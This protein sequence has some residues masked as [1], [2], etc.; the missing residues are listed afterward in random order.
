MT[1]AFS[2]LSTSAGFSAQRQFPVTHTAKPG[3]GAEGAAQNA[4]LRLAFIIE[5]NGVDIVTAVA[6]LGKAAGAI[7]ASIDALPSA[8]TPTPSPSRKVC[9]PWLLPGQRSPAR[10]LA[11][12]PHGR[13][14]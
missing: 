9:S 5:K 1:N 7:L 3:A 6:R 12:L 8:A 2:A 4:F 10:P 11:H 13:R 14:G